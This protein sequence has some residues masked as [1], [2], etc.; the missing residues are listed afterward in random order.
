MKNHWSFQ[1]CTHK[2]AL[3]DP[4]HPKNVSCLKQHPFQ[5]LCLWQRWLKFIRLC[6][7]LLKGAQLSS[8]KRELRTESAVSPYTMWPCAWVA[9]TEQCLTNVQRQR[10]SNCTKME[11][12]HLSRKCTKFI[13]LWGGWDC[14]SVSKSFQSSFQ[15]WYNGIVK[16]SHEHFLMCKMLILIPSS[17]NIHN[18]GW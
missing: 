9:K 16:I 13:G 14:A 17:F 12:Q 1:D 10:C 8:L 6:L 15:S 4:K 7:C 5:Q 2:T 18:L 11:T 3:T